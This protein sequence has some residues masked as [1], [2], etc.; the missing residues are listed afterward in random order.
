MQMLPN[1]VEN[2]RTYTVYVHINKVNGKRYVGITEQKPEIRWNNGN[3]YKGSICF[4]SAIQKYGWDNFDHII[5]EE[6]LSKEDAEREEKRLIK[7][8]NTLSPNGYNLSSGGALSAPSPETSKRL[9]EGHKRYWNSEGAREKH[10]EIIREIWRRPEVR[11]KNLEHL[12]KLNESRIGKKM[13]PAAVRKSA[14]TRGRE[15]EQYSLNGEYIKTHLTISDAAREMNGK[16][17]LIVRVCKGAR[18][19]AYGYKWRYA[20]KL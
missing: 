19:S 8:W 20:T 5:V 14:I 7:E 10:G 13:D 18:I 6:G 15:V 3:N 2:I 11:K 1:I 4:Y 17:S 12:K 16:D 9:S